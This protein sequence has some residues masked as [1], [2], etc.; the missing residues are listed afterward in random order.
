[1]LVSAYR[2][3]RESDLFGILCAAINGALGAV[4]REF[5][6][7]CKEEGVP[8]GP[9]EDEFSPPLLRNML[10]AAVVEAATPAP[11]AKTAAA[12]ILALSSLLEEYA[13]PSRPLDIEGF[14][15]DDLL[16]RAGPATPHDEVAELRALYEVSCL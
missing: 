9:G 11:S 10:V 1:M 5:D 15:N 3:R 16:E 2:A 12:A 7:I 14:V 6:Y 4:L 13:F 8:R